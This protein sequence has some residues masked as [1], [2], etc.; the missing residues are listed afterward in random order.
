MEDYPVVD[1]TFLCGIEDDKKTIAESPISFIFTI[2]PENKD[3][4]IDCYRKVKPM[5]NMQDMMNAALGLYLT[6]IYSDHY[7]TE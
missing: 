5:D 7:I 6:K 2:G 4:F 3:A 1:K